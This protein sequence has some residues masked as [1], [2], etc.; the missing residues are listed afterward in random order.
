MHK[1]KE[2]NIYIFIGHK[3]HYRKLKEMD[4]SD[5]KSSNIS[6][7]ERGVRKK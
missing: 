7:P 6:N 5:Q 3:A 4:Q 1:I 2:N